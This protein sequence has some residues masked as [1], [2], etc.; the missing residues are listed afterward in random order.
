MPF[1]IN[2][3]LAT[4]AVILAAYLLPGVQVSGWLA[5]LAVAVVLGLINAFIRPVLV[6]LTLPIN[7]LTLGLFTIVINAVL[8][9]L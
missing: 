4:I 3:L 5:A 1:I 6:L 8:I 2:W 7:I 9:L